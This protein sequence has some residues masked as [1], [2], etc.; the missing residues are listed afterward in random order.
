MEFKFCEMDG[1]RLVKTHEVL[2]LSREKTISALVL[3]SGR[4]Y[5]LNIKTLDK[6]NREKDE[7]YFNNMEEPYG[8]EIMCEGEDHPE[9]YNEYKYFGL[10]HKKRLKGGKRGIDIK[11]PLERFM[12]WVSGD[13]IGCDF[14][15]VVWIKVWLTQYEDDNMFG[16]EKDFEMS[17]PFYI[18]K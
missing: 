5:M 1:K 12:F 14:C 15:D 17:I 9:F 2:D 10:Q 18:E 8:D 3:K 4:C 11:G 16:K 13:T 7:W 6:K